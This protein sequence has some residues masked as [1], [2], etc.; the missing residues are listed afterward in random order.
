M[1]SPGLAVRAHEG[2]LGCSVEPL[3]S[4]CVHGVVVFAATQKN[5]VPFCTFRHFCRTF[6][7]FSLAYPPP[8]L[9]FSLFFYL[10]RV[11]EYENVKHAVVWRLRT[12]G[13]MFTRQSS[14]VEAQLSKPAS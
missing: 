14:Q 4:K 3:L 9:L 11:L 6:S 5:G 10:I 12:A 13:E 2:K 8:L 1:L 7:H